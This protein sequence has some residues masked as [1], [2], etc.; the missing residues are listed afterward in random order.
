MNHWWYEKDGVATGPVSANELR[1]LLS[2]DEV[3]P[4]VL[5]WCTGF[6]DWWKY[7]SIVA[8]FGDNVIEWAL[9]NM[10]DIKDAE[11][12]GISDTPPPIPKTPTASSS[13]AEQDATYIPLPL[14]QAAPLSDFAGNNRYQKRSRMKHGTNN[15][16]TKQRDG[17]V[18]PWHSKV[19]HE[20]YTIEAKSSAYGGLFGIAFIAALVLFALAISYICEL[21][22]PNNKDLPSQILVISAL[23]IT[24]IY[25][26]RKMKFMVNGM[27]GAAISTVPALAVG[28]MFLAAIAYLYLGFFGISYFIGYGYASL[29]MV[30]IL[31]FRI[32]S[33]IPV[34][35]F[36][37]ANYGFGLSWILAVAIAMPS[38]VIFS[39]FSIAD[40]VRSFKWR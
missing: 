17:D 28:C 13:S 27:I 31:L 26:V 36:F 22:A 35:V 30:A 7:S 38:L 16:A 20:A 21:L 37:G 8:E 39:L 18:L 4:D 29:V 34:A 40:I 24:A 1:R 14:K 10:T 5:V 3:N 19:Q 33:I 9:E 32:D 23:S 15:S 6:G 11:D 2:S 12:D 25:L